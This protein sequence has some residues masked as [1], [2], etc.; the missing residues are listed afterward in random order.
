MLPEVGEAPTRPCSG[1]LNVRWV[2]SN[3][4]PPVR[5]WK[6]LGRDG[7]AVLYED[8]TPGPLARIDGTDQVNS[9]RM[10][11]NEIEVHAALKKPGR[12]MVAE[13]WA[14]GWRA[15]L[16]DE[17]SRLGDPRWEFLGVDLPEG[18]SKVR[19]VYAP[20]SWKLGRWISG[21]GIVVLAGLLILELRR[22]RTPP[23]RP[24]GSLSS[25]SP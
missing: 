6:E 13:T 19:F 5:G 21:F 15:E 3:G 24:S 17:A 7:A 23:I 4:A 9:G 14:P 16:N 10:T 18:E 25:A 1:E 8:P 22:R 2:V 20:S 12:L 11:D